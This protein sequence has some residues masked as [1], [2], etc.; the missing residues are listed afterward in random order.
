MGQTV[1]ARQKSTLVK[2]LLNKLRMS[3]SNDFLNFQRMDAEIFHELALVALQIR[4]KDTI[5]RDATPASQ[6]L[7]ITL[8]FLATG[9][10]FYDMKFLSAL[11]P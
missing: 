3:E 1:I 10:T 2:L 9:N 8:C 4:I 11:S 6:C 7:S 5:M